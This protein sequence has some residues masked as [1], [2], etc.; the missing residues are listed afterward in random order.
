MLVVDDDDDC[1]V[2]VVVDDGDAT[3]DFVGV[4]TGVNDIVAVGEDGISAI[5]GDDNDDEVDFVV[6]GFCCSVIKLASS[7]FCN[8]CA[9]QNI[10][11]IIHREED[12]RF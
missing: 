7:A 10:S 8:N 11:N 5:G 2:V 6:V 1:D 3:I 9:I 4:A 12:K